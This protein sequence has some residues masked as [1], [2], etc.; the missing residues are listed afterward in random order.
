MHLSI[1]IKALNE[2]QNIAAC[3]ESAIA[4][5]AGMDAEVIVVDSLSTDRTVEIARRYPVRIVQ[6]V[7]RSEC[8]CGAAVQLGYQFAR[9]EYVYVL[10]GDMVLQADFIRSA[11]T[12]LE[13]APH[14][15]G[16]G[17]KL[18]DTR[19][20]S[21]YD[22]RRLARA[23]ALTQPVAVAELGGGG[24]YRRHAIRDV[25]YLGHRWLPAFEEVELGMRLRSAGWGLLR[26]PQV[27]VFHTGHAET[28]W[29]MLGRLWRNRRAHATGMLLR[30]AL[31]KKWWWRA[32]RKQK[33]I[34]V[35]AA[36]HFGSLGVAV[37]VGPIYGYG[38][39]FAA[40]EVAFWGPVI[41]GLTVKKGSLYLAA[42]SIVASHYFFCAAIVGCWKGL[43]DP[44]LPIAAR[45]L[46]LSPALHSSLRAGQ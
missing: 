31:G 42:F 21:P 3:I 33:H 5:V 23:A 20:T 34:F 26:L 40:A 44:R 29:R 22:Y 37:V 11:L 8:N 4:A 41:A 35:P 9:G 1:I 25:D 6:F 17:G 14:L 45:E 7:H 18:L 10:D 43:A 32:L 30:A 39:A 2:E 36:G 27:A 12:M 13:S 38:I 24:L 46:T 15:A 16:V 28:G 19:V